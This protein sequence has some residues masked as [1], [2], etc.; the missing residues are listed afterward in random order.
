MPIPQGYTV[1]AG[2]ETPGLGINFNY[3]DS[4]RGM[5]PQGGGGFGAEALF[6]R[7]F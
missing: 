2:Y 1:K 3:R 7:R 5:S 6:N 4:R